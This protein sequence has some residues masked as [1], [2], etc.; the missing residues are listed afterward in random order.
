MEDARRRHR[1][2][3]P[4]GPRAL[5]PRK[6]AVVVADARPEHGEMR[7]IPPRRERHEVAR[8]EILAFARREGRQ[9]VE[10]ER[11]H[12]PRR[13][14]GEGRGNRRARVGPVEREAREAE[15][16]DRG[17][18]CAREIAHHRSGR[19][20]RVRVAV[21]RRIERDHRV[22]I[23]ERIQQ[24]QQRRR[25]AR[26]GVQRHYRR[27]A[28]GP[29]IVDIPVSHADQAALD[30]V[31]CRVARSEHGPAAA[32]RPAGLRTSLRIRACRSAAR[33]S[34]RRRT[35]RCRCRPRS[36]SR[37]SSWCTRRGPRTC[38]RS[39]DSRPRRSRS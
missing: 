35:S 1:D 9:T 39:S 18:E 2:R 4:R 24:R 29:A 26:R 3:E 12:P 10:H 37:R 14:E 28:T 31:A 27:A 34:T 36:S 6:P 7:A 25:R 16:V 13:L 20:E 23:G 11:L 32:Q 21:A 30:R 22:T 38:P 17:A 15:T 5:V 8:Q 19:R 33:R